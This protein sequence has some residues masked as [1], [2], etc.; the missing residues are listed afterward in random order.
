VLVSVEIRVATPYRNE[1]SAKNDTFQ[2]VT[3]QQLGLVTDVE[4]VA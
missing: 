4:K 1:R 3:T 2:E